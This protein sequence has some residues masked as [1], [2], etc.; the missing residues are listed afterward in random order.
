MN[1]PN[2]APFAAGSRTPATEYRPADNDVRHMALDTLSQRAI[3]ESR[4]F[5]RHEEYDSRY[6]YELFRRA[7]V[8]QDQLAWNQLFL[9]YSPL[10]DHWIRRVGVFA[11][12]GETSE[13]FV[14]AA[15]TRFWR[16]I[17]PQRF[18]SFR[19]LAALLNYLRS[20]AT[21][22]VI[23]SARAQS[24]ADLLSEDQINW[25]RQRLAHADEEATERVSRSE[26]W[27]M[28]DG[29]LQNDA[30]RTVVYCSFV[31]GMK[32]GDIFERYGD[33]FSDIAQVYTCKRNVLN[34]LR[35]NPLLRERV[36]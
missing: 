33:L 8:D 22:V 13:S 34:R 27:R 15:F 19:T 4:R 30:E 10:V 12:S 3:T 28:I 14:C 35:R 16:A 11:V 24:H 31:L 1:R 26:F 23:D 32:P 36:G 21:C 20:C 29:L 5:Y 18:P 7:L 17:P 25:N 9:Q 6:A 2:V